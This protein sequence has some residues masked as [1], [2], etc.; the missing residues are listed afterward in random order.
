MSKRTQTDSLALYPHPFSRAYWREAAKD[1]TNLRKLTVAAL[2]CALAIVIE[3]F[4]IP[5]G[6]QGLQISMSFPAISLCSLLTGPLLAIPCGVI[7]D[8]IGISISGYGF[9]AG[10]T[11]TAVL[12][13]VV[14]ALFLYRA[15]PSF[16]RIL[17][18]KGII[19]LF[20][21]T[22]LGSVWRVMQQGGTYGYWALLSG[23]K[24]LCLLPLEVFILCILF[25]ALHT[26]LSQQNLLSPDAKAV[27]SRR[28]FVLLTVFA[29]IGAALIVPL[30]IW[31]KDIRAF[32]QGLF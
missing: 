22:L 13:A 26:P 25:Q 16:M 12:T 15:R 27:Y 6:T 10:Y 9:F 17:F 5:L 2:L 8:L 28:N 29:L 32:I 3:I 20:I 1:C 21:N 4:N 7:V 14:Y 11:L 19:N 31:Y 30:A 23:V 18:A 24:N